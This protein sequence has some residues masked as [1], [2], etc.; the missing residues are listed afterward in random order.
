MRCRSGGAIIVALSTCTALNHCWI[1][2]LNH[3]KHNVVPATWTSIVST[4][5]LPNSHLPFSTI[6]GQNWKRM[7]WRNKIPRFRLSL[8]L[9]LS[10]YLSLH[11]HLQWAVIWQRR[12]CS[13]VAS[14]E[15][16][17]NTRLTVRSQCLMHLQKG[18]PASIMWDHVISRVAM[19]DFSISF[20]AFHIFWL[21]V[22][23][24]PSEKWWSE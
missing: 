4:S 17:L 15:V 21:V 12:E 11:R 1:M 16:P 8:S 24:Y 20:P 10:L 3:S 22:S 2:M 18:L 7:C 23:T 9:S 6:L 5:W 14:S 19:A 13:Y